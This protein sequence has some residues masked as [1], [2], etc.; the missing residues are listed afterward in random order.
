MQYLPWRAQNAY[1]THLFCQ[2]FSC[3]LIRDQW[4]KHTSRVQ[5]NTCR[6]SFIWCFINPYFNAFENIS[7]WPL[8]LGVAFQLLICC[9]I[10]ISFLLSL[11]NGFAISCSK[12]IIQ[13]I[14]LLQMGNDKLL[15]LPLYGVILNQWRAF[16][17]NDILDHLLKPYLCCKLL[18]Y[19]MFMSIY[20][21][22]TLP[23]Y[24]FV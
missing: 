2:Y 24:S 21:S 10:K 17:V 18:R 20:Y 8:L 1:W 6:F 3:Q 5:N 22:F 23:P 9:A 13:T 4:I 11:S 16:Y 12:Y 7:V 15:G 19:V 14:S